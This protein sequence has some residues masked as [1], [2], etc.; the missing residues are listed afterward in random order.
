MTTKTVKNEPLSPRTEKGKQD[1]LSPRVKKE[2]EKL[3]SAVPQVDTERVKILLD[4]YQNDG[5]DPNII[6]RAKVFNRFCSEKTIF[7]DDNPIVGTLSQY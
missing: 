6:R 5:T 4:V 3:L 1:L 2:K 7:I